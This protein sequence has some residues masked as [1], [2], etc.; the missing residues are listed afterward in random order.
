MTTANSTPAIR[1]HNVSEHMI[2]GEQSISQLLNNKSGILNYMF[3]F[4]CD[5]KNDF[6]F[7]ISE[8]RP[9]YAQAHTESLANVSRFVKFVRTEF[10][11]VCPPYKGGTRL[12]VSIRRIENSN[13]VEFCFKNFHIESGIYILNAP[14]GKDF[15]AIQCRDSRIFSSNLVKVLCPAEYRMFCTENRNNRCVRCYEKATIAIKECGH[16]I[17]CTSC[18]PRTKKCAICLAVQLQCQPHKMSF[19]FALSQHK[20][21]LSIAGHSFGFS[22]TVFSTYMAINWSNVTPARACVFSASQMDAIG[23]DPFLS[24]IELPV[25]LLLIRLILLIS[26]VPFV[27]RAPPLNVFLHLLIPIAVFAMGI[28]EVCG[29]QIA[30]NNSYFGAAFRLWFAFTWCNITQ[31]YILITS[32]L[33]PVVPIEIDGVNEKPK[34]KVKFVHVKPF[35]LNVI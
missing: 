22:L 6:M 10:K 31:L 11:V 30:S 24:I 9:K 7:G 12:I 18:N 20:S 2:I 4:N 33:W 1:M 8:M 29:F 5:V 28:V 21:S 17:Y 15:L 13:A 27:E 34:N 23:R 32:A 35:E 16:V 19:N 3:L 14:P 25:V 26:S